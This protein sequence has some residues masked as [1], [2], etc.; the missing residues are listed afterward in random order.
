M[1]KQNSRL[2][3]AGAAAALLLG[4]VAIVSAAQR[5]T[6][7]GGAASVEPQSPIGTAVGSA[8]LWAAINADGSTARSD[9]G[10]VGATR[11]LPG[12][13]GS[14]EVIF[15]RNVTGCIYV[16]TIGNAGAGNPLHGSIV[17]AARAGNVNGVFVETR[18]SPTG[19][20]SDRPFHLFV[21]C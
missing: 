3:L 15:R 13:N 19:P 20:L 21:N 12:F 7:N 14:Y 17:V 10:N 1:T 16:A 18:D 9:G 4:S 5:G 8:L 6:S 2:L 11:K